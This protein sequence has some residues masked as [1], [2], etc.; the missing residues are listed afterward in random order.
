MKK[1]AAFLFVVFIPLLIWARSN[2][3]P[4]IKDSSGSKW[5][6]VWH[7]E[8]NNNSTIDENWSAENASP[9]HIMSSRWREN[10]SVKSGKL[11]IKNLKENKGGKEWTSGSMTSKRKFKYGY[12]ECRMRISSISGVNNSF[13]LY[14]TNPTSISGHKFEIDVIEG[15]YPNA[16]LSNI[17]DNGTKT[18]SYDKQKSMTYKVSTNLYRKYHTFG[19]EWNKDSLKFYVD[20][21]LTRSEPNTCC[22]DEA[23]VI[24]GTAVMTWAGKVTDKINGTSMDVDYVRIY[25][26]K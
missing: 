14:C 18:N 26:R 22:F 5:D 23:P 3:K 7:D 24:L 11:I 20:G 17:H 25:Q 12:F 4:C 8:F 15:H 21:I 2:Y 6:L 16:V 13:W 10:L 9:G 19:L 1:L